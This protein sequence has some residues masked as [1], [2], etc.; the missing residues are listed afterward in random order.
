MNEYFNR[1]KNIPV[2]VLQ[3]KKNCRKGKN[4]RLFVD[5]TSLLI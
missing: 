2:M 1:N 5:K 3:K 4:T